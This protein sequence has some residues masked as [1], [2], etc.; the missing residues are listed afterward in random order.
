MGNETASLSLIKT[1]AGQ[2]FMEVGDK[3]YE[4]LSFFVCISCDT[5]LGTHCCSHGTHKR[6]EHTQTHCIQCEHKHINRFPFTC[7]QMI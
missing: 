7:I 2:W 4:S 5:S 1:Y 6:N 3:E